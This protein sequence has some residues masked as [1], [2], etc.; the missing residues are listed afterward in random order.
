MPDKKFGLARFG[1]M[2]ATSNESRGL[3]AGF[4]FKA[5]SLSG[6]SFYLVGAIELKRGE[7]TIGFKKVM[8]E[9]RNQGGSWTNLE[10]PING[11]LEAYDFGPDGRVWAVAAGNRIQVLMR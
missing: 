5:F 7:E 2:A 3:P 10:L 8:F 4:L 1:E 11:S 9:S 6:D